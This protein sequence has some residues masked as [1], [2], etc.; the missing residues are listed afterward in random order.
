MLSFLVL[1]KIVEWKAEGEDLVQR[2]D[3]SHDGLCVVC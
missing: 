1:L 2:L 3:L